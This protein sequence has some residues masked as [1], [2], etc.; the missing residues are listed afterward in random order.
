MNE[1]LLSGETAES[2][3]STAPFLEESTALSVRTVT[4]AAWGTA[5]TED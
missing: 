4:A 3:V 1:E 2:R 5:I